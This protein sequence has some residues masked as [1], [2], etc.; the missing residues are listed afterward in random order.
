M[1]YKEKRR[2]R[3]TLNASYLGD[4][5]NDPIGLLAAEIVIHAIAD[6]RELVKARKW[7]DPSPQARC[8]FDELRAFFKGEWCDFIMQKFDMSPIALLAM[9]EA[10]LAEAQRLPP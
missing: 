5:E 9:L 8:N 7:N 3:A 2:R 6:W 4:Y 1:T 10:E